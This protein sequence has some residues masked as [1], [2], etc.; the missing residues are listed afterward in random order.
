MIPENASTSRPAF[1]VQASSLLK[2]RGRPA[3]KKDQHLIHPRAME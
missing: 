2:L 3:P 1:V